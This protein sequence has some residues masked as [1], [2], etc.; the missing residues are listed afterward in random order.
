M[1]PVTACEGGGTSCGVGLSSSIGADARPT[2][3]T[4]RSPASAAPLV[5][6]IM[7]LRSALSLSEAMAGS[8]SSGSPWSKLVSPS[9][10]ARERRARALDGRLAVALLPRQRGAT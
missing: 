5:V 10:I 2:R 6:R 3:S 8:A 4:L 1:V 9:N 7:P